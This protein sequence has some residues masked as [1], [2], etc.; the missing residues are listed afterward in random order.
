MDK[1]LKYFLRAL[2]VIIVGYII[3]FIGD[4]MIHGH[5][6]DWK[7]WKEYTYLF[8]KSIIQDVDTFLAVSDI[9]RNDVLTMFRYVSNDSGK[10]GRDKFNYNPKDTAYNVF[11]WEFKKLSHLKI[12]DI[13]IRTNQNLD[14]LKL[15]RGEILDSKSDQRI[16]IHFGFEYE[17][18]A[19]NVDNHSKIEKK[20]EGRNY[21]GFIGY[22]NRISLSNENNEHEIF[23]DYVPI[24]KQVLF[25]IY[26]SNERFYIIIID[27][28][29]KF[30]ESIMSIL[31]LK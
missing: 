29:K 13:D 3:Y 7:K 1:K 20:I 28:E 12:D 27:S 31:N 10:K 18:M 26:N 23:I 14:N 25:L 8:N 30:D 24:Q 4:Y 9:T 5:S 6:T 15:K 19:V 22:I 16:S 2:T 11:F 17:S 21:K